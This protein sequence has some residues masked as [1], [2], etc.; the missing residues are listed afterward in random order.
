ML[1]QNFAKAHFIDGIEI[2]KI[3]TYTPTKKVVK[4]TPDYEKAK[5]KSFVFDSKH[6]FGE[7]K[8]SDHWKE[9]AVVRCNSH[10]RRVEFRRRSSPQIQRD[11]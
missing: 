1:A 7:G 4:N 3:T 2:V 10:R 9:A 11:A 6:R 5:S 8:N